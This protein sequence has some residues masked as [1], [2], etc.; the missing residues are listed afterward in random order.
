MTHNPISEN[1][2][3]DTLHKHER[4]K[5]VYPLD[6]IVRHVF[7]Q[8]PRNKDQRKKLKLLDFGS[9]AGRNVVFLARE[10]FQAYGT[11]ISIEGDHIFQQK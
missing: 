11:D 4:F 2:S 5:P 7:T 10:G 3:W 8:L 1:T 6:Y 9:G